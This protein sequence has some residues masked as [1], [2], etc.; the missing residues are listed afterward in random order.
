M[1]TTPPPMPFN[2]S[3]KRFVACNED[4]K[5]RSLIHHEP[6]H[7]TTSVWRWDPPGGYN[8]VVTC[9]GQQ[10]QSAEDLAVELAAYFNEKYPLPPAD[11]QT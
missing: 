8:R 7:Q 11:A 5:T 4:P 1:S 3:G 9:H 6:G 2:P 10:G